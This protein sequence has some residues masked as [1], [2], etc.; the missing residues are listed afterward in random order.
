MCIV[1]DDGILTAVLRVPWPHR[2]MVFLLFLNLFL[3]GLYLSDTAVASP[4]AEAL[5]SILRNPC[6]VVFLDLP[7]LLIK[8]QEQFF[9]VDHFLY[10]FVVPNLFQ[11]IL[12]NYDANE[13]AS[14]SFFVQDSAKQN[15]SQLSFLNQREDKH[16]RCLIG[17]AWAENVN[18]IKN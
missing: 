18:W 10:F 5:S 12:D 15:I 11:G 8:V 3:A 17:V 16:Q 9:P 1:A 13:G 14:A 7:P 6:T 2:E 4:M